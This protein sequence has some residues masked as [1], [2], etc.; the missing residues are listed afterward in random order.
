VYGHPGYCAMG[1]LGCHEDAVGAIEA[2]RDLAA[3]YRAEVEARDLPLTVVPALHLI[4]D[5]AQAGPGADGRYLEQMPL[6]EIQ[7]WVDAARAE[8]IPIFLDVQ[9]GWSDLREGVERLRSF[10]EEPFVHLAVDPEFMTEAAGYAPGKVI[11]TL[12]AEDANWVQ[13]YLAGIVRDG[14]LPP[15]VL[16]LHQFHPAMLDDPE[17]YA[18]VAEVEITIDM[19]GW[20]PPWPKAEHYEWYALAPYAE[21]PAIKIFEKWDEPLMT[22][23]DVLALPV[24]PAYL[25]YQ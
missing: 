1:A 21:R 15:K 19:D 18:D 9:V 12:G 7:V 24:I 8:G 10:L 3:E 17:D 13:E 5:V 2:V 4:V 23:A 25:I 20:G 14:G 22:P 6:D 11:G 16:V